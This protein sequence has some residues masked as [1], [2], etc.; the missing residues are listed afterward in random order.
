MPTESEKQGEKERVTRIS[1]FRVG[2]HDLLA[3]VDLEALR[4]PGME[5]A[6]APRAAFMAAACIASAPPAGAAR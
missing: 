5:R 6:A 1:G 4:M 3:E 2:Y